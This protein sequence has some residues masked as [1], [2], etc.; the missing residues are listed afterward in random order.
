MNL[1]HISEDPSIERFEPRAANKHSGLEGE[2]LVWAIE[3]RLL[4]NY[5]LP[6]DCPRVT[7]YKADSSQREDIEKLMGQTTARFVVAIE[8]GWFERASKGILYNYT[9]NADTFEVSDEGAG[10]YVSRASVKPISVTTI[11]HP[12]E[13]MLR[14]NV[15][16]RVMPSLKK[17]QEAVMGSSLQFSCIRMRNA[18]E[19]AM[20]APAT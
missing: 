13:E 18:Q 16:L 9:L 7:F 14:R 2:L 17:L 12:L 20:V 1:F 15:E 19:Q 11:E 4:H 8:S 5:L 6:R 3:D 10:Y